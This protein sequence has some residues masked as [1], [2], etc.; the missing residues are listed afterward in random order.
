MQFS[1]QHNATKLELARMN[2]IDPDDRFEPVSEPIV[3]ESAAGWYIG[4]VYRDA[5]LN[6]L[7]PW[8][9][10]SQYMT[11]SMAIQYYEW[12]VLGVQKP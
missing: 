10:N 4:Q 1:T 12:D 3:M 7:L 2:G 5:E 11:E 8:S 6:C 9:R